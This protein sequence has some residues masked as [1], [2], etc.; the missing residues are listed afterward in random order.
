[1]SGYVPRHMNT[2]GKPI[3][4]AVT[5]MR[6]WPGAGWGGSSSTSC[7]TSIGSPARCTCQA[8]ITRARQA[9]SNASRRF[10][11]IDEGARAVEQ[12]IDL[13]AEELVDWLVGVASEEL[14]VAALE[15]DRQL[16]ARK[17]VVPADRGRR[18]TRSGGV[19]LDEAGAIGEVGHVELRLL[20]H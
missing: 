4:A 8:R 11:A 12:Q 15:N 2:S 16:P 10:F 19:A 14:R 1:V 20:R 3:P 18:P 13:G 9:R 7:K 6:T 5:R 17:H